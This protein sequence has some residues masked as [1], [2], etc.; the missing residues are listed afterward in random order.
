MPAA[1]S[2]RRAIFFSPGAAQAARDALQGGA[3]IFCDAT[4]GRRRGHARAP[5]GEQRGHLHAL[6]PVHARARRQA[7]H[8]AH[9]GGNRALAPRLGGSVVA[10]GN[11]PTALFR[12]LEMIDAGAPLPAAVI[13]MPVGFVGAAE[14][15]GGADRERPAGNS[16]AWPARAAA[17]WRWRLST[18]SRASGMTVLGRL[19]GVGWTRRPRTAHGESDPRHRRGAR[20]R[21]LRQG[22]AAGQCARDRRLLV[23]PSHWNCRSS[24][25]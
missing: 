22:G 7:R 8:D 20:R 21:L 1:W 13:G 3:P 12:L 11:A 25:R 14:V 18:R 10:I 23:K 17:R 5:A 2:R 19:Y 6:R 15:E 16:R 9:G 4:H 24:T